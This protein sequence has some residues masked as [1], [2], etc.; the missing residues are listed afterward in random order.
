MF[1]HALTYNF[2]TLNV[3]L[4][5][6]AKFPSYLYLVLHRIF[7]FSFA[8]GFIYYMALVL[9]LLVLVR[10]LNK[11]YHWESFCCVTQFHFSYFDLECYWYFAWSQYCHPHRYLCKT[12]SSIQKL[13]HK[14][15]LKIFRLPVCRY[16]QHIVYLYIFGILNPR[17]VIAKCMLI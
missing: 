8:K 14:N 12:T 6:R 7:V 4:K 2:D 10:V 13:I 11:H 1:Q 5:I 15:F 16:H 9:L 3:G 17:W